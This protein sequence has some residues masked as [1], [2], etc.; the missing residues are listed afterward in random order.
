MTKRDDGVGGHASPTEYSVNDE[1]VLKFDP[2]T[3]TLALSASVEECAYLVRFFA[4]REDKPC[5]LFI[6][7]CLVPGE[8][9]DMHFRGVRR[10][11]SIPPEESGYWLYPSTSE[12]REV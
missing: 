10:I 3:G 2:E 9:A 8:P 6:P 12:Y 7:G 5:N 4:V 11:A 1:L